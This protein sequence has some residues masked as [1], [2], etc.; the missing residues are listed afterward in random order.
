MMGC[1]TQ[2][3]VQYGGYMIV[4][5]RE[6]ASSYPVAPGTIMVFS[7]PDRKKMFQKITGYTYYDK[8]QFLEYV[9]VDEK[10]Q[11]GTENDSTANSLLDSISALK[12]QIESLM[13]EIKSIKKDL[14]S[15]GG[16]S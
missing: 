15:E 2:Q 8:P 3:S 1:Q 4:N 5:G 16:E 14:Y 9:L 12:S 11:I 7:T 6:D 10:A 13:G